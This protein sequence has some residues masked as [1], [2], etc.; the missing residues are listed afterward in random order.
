MKDAEVL[1]L[2]YMI[3]ANPSAECPHLEKAGLYFFFHFCIDF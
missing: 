1:K 3:T 2:N